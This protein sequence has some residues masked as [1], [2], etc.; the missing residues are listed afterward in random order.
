MSIYREITGSRRTETGLGLTG[1][2][3][4]AA[5]NTVD[6]IVIYLLSK[7]VRDAVIGPQRLAPDPRGVPGQK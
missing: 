6:F 3:R 4:L 2:R 5:R 1:R 7:A